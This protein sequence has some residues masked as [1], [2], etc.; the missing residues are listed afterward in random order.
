MFPK[1]H[2]TTCLNYKQANRLNFFKLLDTKQKTNIENHLINKDFNY[3]RCFLHLCSVFT[4]V[5]VT[6]FEPATSR[7]LTER[8]TKLSHT[9]LGYASELALRGVCFQ[10]FAKLIKPA[11]T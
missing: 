7:S 10:L 5:G 11:W 2:Y 3:V 8:S 9:P 6:G 1:K 4:E